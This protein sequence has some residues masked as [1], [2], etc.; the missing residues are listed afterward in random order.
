MGV[1]RG[2]EMDQLIKNIPDELKKL[3]NWVGW[4][5]KPSKDRPGKFDKVP[6]DVLHNCHAKSNRSS[7][8]TDFETALDLSIQRGYDGIGFMFQ[9]PYV[10]V[11]QDDCIVK[12]KINQRVKSILKELNCYTEVSPSGK[13]V[14]TICKGS[15]NRSINNSQV[16]LEIYGKGRF[17]TVT[18]NK[19][20]E[21]SDVVEDKTD[22][23]NKL[24]EKYKPG[25]WK[26]DYGSQSEADLA[27]C[28]KLAFWT[29]RDAGQIDA[30]FR[31]SKLYR[32]KSIK[33][34]VNKK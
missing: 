30:I 17:F 32:A 6:M 4:K 28:N 8:W 27:L 23:L 3:P 24:I 19:R 15:I 2:V 5:L 33:K 22:F 29:S 21:Y 12:G 11:D 26:D 10:G 9:P 20:D 25:K 7:T 16:D 31:Q 13:G 1:E 34:G 14:H 18:G